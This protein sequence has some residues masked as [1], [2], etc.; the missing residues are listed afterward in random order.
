LSGKMQRPNDGRV[1]DNGTF[2]LNDWMF[3]EGLKGTFYAIDRQGNVVTRKL[4]QANLFNNGISSDGRFAVC[5]TCNSDNADSGILCFF[6]LLAGAILWAKPP[7]SGW[8]DSYEFDVEKEL[9]Y[10]VYMDVGKF[11]Y[12]FS[13]EFL[14]SERWQTERIKRANGFELSAIARE[15]FQSLDKVV[16]TE[17]G[18]EILT[19][20]E[21]ALQR[22]LD[23]YPN[24]QA[25][26]YRTMGEVFEALGEKLKAIEHY[27]RALRLNPKV[28]IKR[29]LDTLRKGSA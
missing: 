20:L 1:A 3:G 13:G 17:T 26:V 15:R 2:V 9:L 19:L 29:R 25:M 22:G 11:V 4:F 24:E 12:N 8:A 6:D 7:E 27:E 18:E 28:G 16:N 21:Q 5:Q 10:L 23:N 14:D